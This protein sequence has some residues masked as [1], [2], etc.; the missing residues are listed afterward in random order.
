MDLRLRGNVGQDLFDTLR[1][2]NHDDFDSIREVQKLLSLGNGPW[3]SALYMLDGMNCSRS[4]VY[5]S[6]FDQLIFQL[7]KEIADKSQMELL[8]LL[9]S[10]VFVSIGTNT[11]LR[12]ILV[13]ILKKLSVV[14]ECYLQLFIKYGC[15]NV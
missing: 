10:P 2:G 14:P 12:P 15:L 5:N 7:N 9:Q 11:V 3:N 8:R 4:T 1:K 6:L 13:G